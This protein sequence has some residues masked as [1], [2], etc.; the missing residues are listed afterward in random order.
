M[1]QKKEK[2]KGPN[3]WKTKPTLL[4]SVGFWISLCY[5]QYEIYVPFR[6]S[7]KLWNDTYL[8]WNDIYLIIGSVNVCFKGIGL[9]NI[10]R[11]F[12]WENKKQLIFF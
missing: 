7:Y 2:K 3:K 1:I 4:Y 11:I 9:E 10:F 6:T 8:I 5:L 12:L